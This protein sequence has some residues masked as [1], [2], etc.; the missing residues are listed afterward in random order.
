MNLIIDA[1]EK[2]GERYRH[3]RYVFYEPIVFYPFYEKNLEKWGHWEAIKKMISNGDVKLFGIIPYLSKIEKK[4]FPVIQRILPK[5]IEFLFYEDMKTKKFKI[6]DFE[7]YQRLNFFPLDKIFS[8]EFIHLIN[9]ECE[10]M[11]NPQKYEFD[12]TAPPITLLPQL[13]ALMSLLLPMGLVVLQPP[14]KE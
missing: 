10:F 6:G 8:P 1:A 12:E 13:P 4:P 2:A 3:V 5:S 7:S 9:S 11:R 14:A